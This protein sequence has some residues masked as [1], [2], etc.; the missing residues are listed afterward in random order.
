MRGELEMMRTNT[1]LMAKRVNNVD[2]KDQSALAPASCAQDARARLETL[3]AA[4]Q[5]APHR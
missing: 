4:V 2:D 5:E 3:R 1:S